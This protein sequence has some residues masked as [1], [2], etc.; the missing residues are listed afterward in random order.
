MGHN[1]RS[2]QRAHLLFGSTCCICTVIQ[3][4][5]VPTELCPAWAVHISSPGTYVRLSCNCRFERVH[6]RLGEIE[7]RW[8]RWCSSCRLGKISVL[9]TGWAYN[10]KTTTWTFEDRSTLDVL[11]TCIH[12]D[13]VP[14]FYWPGRLSPLWK[15]VSLCGST[16]E[17]LGSVRHH[18][19]TD[20]PGTKAKHKFQHSLY[21]V[22]FF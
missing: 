21:D 4:E 9:C 10:I 7:R 5:L 11:I 14:D 3:C 1:R 12:P 16:H 20:D 13:L 17:T 2:P 6:V 22:P 15:V 18:V 8:Y 19:R